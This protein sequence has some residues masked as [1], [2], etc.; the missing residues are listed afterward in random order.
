MSVSNFET[1]AGQMW[2]RLY[3]QRPDLPQELQLLFGSLQQYLGTAKEVLVSLPPQFSA[4]MGRYLQIYLH[5]LTKLNQVVDEKQVAGALVE[6]FGV[7]QFS[8]AVPTFN[9]ITGFLLNAERI[10]KLTANETTLVANEVKGLIYRI[11]IHIHEKR[12]EELES[13]LQAEETAISLFSKEAQQDERSGIRS[14]I[15]KAKKKFRQTARNY[16]LEIQKLRLEQMTMF[17][18]VS[19]MTGKTVQTQTIVKRRYKVNPSLAAT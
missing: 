2:D 9:L 5:S 15:A 8:A 19:G 4:E 14:A 3:P 10:A 17:K 1:K 11:N 7:P 16:K 13:K 6:R 18:L 12:V